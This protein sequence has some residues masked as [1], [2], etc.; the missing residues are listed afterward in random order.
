MPTTR[1]GLNS[2]AIE[3]LIA[4]CMADAMTAFEANQNSGNGV[5]N[6]TSGRQKEPL[7]NVTFSKP[8]KI[9]EAIHL[10]HDLMDQVKRSKA[11]KGVDNK[12]KWDD[13]RN[14]SGQ[15]NKRQEVVRAFTAGTGE[16]RETRAKEIKTVVK[17]L[18]EE[19]FVIG[20]GKARQDPDVVTGYHQFKVRDKD[21]PKTA[22]RTHYGHY[23]FQVTP[24][25]LTNAPTGILVDLAEI[26]A[27][28]DW[29]TPTTPTK[30]RQCIGLVGDYQRF[31]E[32]F[33]KIA[34]PL[35]KLTQ[36]NQKC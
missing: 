19:R 9:Q 35:P 15:Q 34:K 26:E 17:E 12:R 13:N 22:F 16:R 25:G 33:S 3:K 31:I 29:A 36:K 2:T 4:Q 5:N 20:G 23:E 11:A 6:E 27:I 28:K 24:I 14:N 1:Q 10:A 18:G 7:G 8:T 21:I 30:I 32:G